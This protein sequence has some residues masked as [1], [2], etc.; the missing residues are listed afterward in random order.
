MR[1]A[2]AACN[3]P[4]DLLQ[5]EGGAISATGVEKAAQQGFGRDEP[6]CRGDLPKD[7]RSPCEAAV[8]D[9]HAEPDIL[10]PGQP[11]AGRLV[12]LEGALWSLGENLECVLRR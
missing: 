4:V 9:R 11:L 6:D 8:L 10:K 12:E 3:E 1:P 7:V 2:L 5:V